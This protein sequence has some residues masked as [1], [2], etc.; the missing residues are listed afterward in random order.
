MRLRQSIVLRLVSF[1]MCIGLIWLMAACAALSDA[2]QA[3]SAATSAPVAVQPTTAMTTAPAA[4]TSA[5]AAASPTTAASANSTDTVRL[6]FVS[7]DNEARYR[8]REQLARLSFPSDA[9]GA[10]RS[11]TGT[12]V[13]K[14]DGTISSESKVQV[15]LSTLKSD[16]NQRDNFIKMNTLQTSRYR[17]ATFVP[18]AIQGLSLPPKSGP[19]SFKLIGNLTIRDVTKQ[20]TWDVSGTINSNEATGTATT[21]F[22]WDYFNLSKPSVFTVLSVEDT[23]KLEIDLHLR[24]VTA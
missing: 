9:V 4:S 6:E 13:A 14:A 17:Y 12:I 16:E 3:N 5:P 23:I 11:V 8:V 22:T 15:D 20:V 2:G 19:V 1:G 24:R 10:T 21:S 18:T 7:G